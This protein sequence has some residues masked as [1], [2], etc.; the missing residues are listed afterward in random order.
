MNIPIVDLHCDLLCYLEKD[1]RR[2]PYDQ[3]ARCAIP[4]L[5]QGY[6][7]LQTM[8][9]FT[10]TET[11]SSDKGLHQAHLYQELPQHYPKDIVHFSSHWN[12]QSPF[13]AILM[14]FENAS[15]FCNEDEPLQEGFKR[16]KHVI[17][18]IAKPLYM[19]L[20]WNTENRFG[21]GALTSVGLKT[22][23]K[24]LLE[25]LDQQNI[26]IDLSHA[27][28]ALAYE[29][30]D[31]I[32]GH[33]LNI[34]IMASH[35]NARS[36]TSVPRNLPNDIAQEIFR[37]GGIIGL[38]LYRHFIGETED[39]LIKHF[40]H[41]LELGGENHLVSGSDFFY[42]ADFPSTYRHGKEVFF[43]NYE[44]A[45]CYGKLLSFLQREL[46]LSP[47]FLEKFAHQNALAFIYSFHLKP[48]HL[49]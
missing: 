19:S 49:G 11:H 10:Q 39:Q 36:V 21:G 44:D 35:S 13:I 32:E 3:A 41:W 43:R 23:G 30:I 15:G 14:A 6:V 20:T 25:E 47:S 31:Y 40:A 8:A 38:N 24:L 1:K 4:Q 2:T 42:D 46:K 16:L 26:A 18:T 27:S 17:H 5:R 29:I 37:R 28:D 9:I 45:S 34:P 33:R 12:L 22:E 7:K 48:G